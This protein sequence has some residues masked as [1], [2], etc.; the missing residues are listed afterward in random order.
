MEAREL[1]RVT[2]VAE[3]EREAEEVL[4]EESVEPS[5]QEIEAAEE[6]A[7]KEELEVTLI[8]LCTD[9]CVISN[10][11]VL[12]AFFPEIPIHVDASCCAG[13]TPKSHEI[14]LDAMRMCQIN[15]ER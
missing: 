10:A 3:A 12:K 2:D 14:A 13:V 15:I 9:I 4:S 6:Q 7:E 1:K 8:G 5:E 11:M